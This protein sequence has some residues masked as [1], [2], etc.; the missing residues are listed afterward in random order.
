MPARIEGYI[1]VD[2][3]DYADE[4]EIHAD[5]DDIADIMDANNIDIDEMMEYLDVQHA[6]SLNDVERYITDVCD[7]DAVIKVV[8]VCMKRFLV[9]Y[10]T[11]FSQMVEN[12]RDA[13]QAKAKIELLTTTPASEHQP[14]DHGKDGWRSEGR[15]I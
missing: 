12:A 14:E 2:V 11:T 4:I 1:T 5:A 6:T 10:Q 3:S 13:D 7:H 8:N 9:D 15:S